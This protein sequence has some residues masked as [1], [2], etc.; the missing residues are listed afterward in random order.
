MK[1]IQTSLFRIAGVWQLGFPGINGKDRAEL[2]GLRGFRYNP[3]AGLWHITFHA[4]TVNFLNNKFDGRYYFLKDPTPRDSVKDFM[5]EEKVKRARLS[6]YRES[7][8]LAVQHTYDRHLYAELKKIE[9]ARYD[10]SKRCWLFSIEQHFELVKLQLERHQFEIIEEEKKL[11]NSVGRISDRRSSVHRS[12]VIGAYLFRFER[13]LALRNQSQRTIASYLGC[14]KVFLAQFKDCD[15][16]EI[17]HEEIRNYLHYLS[18]KHSYSFSTLNL[19]ISAIKSFYLSIFQLRLRQVELPRPKSAKDLPKVIAEDQVKR[20]IE[21]TSN[22]KHRTIL[23][24]MYST[25]I[26]RDEVLGIKL[27]DLSIQEKHILIHGKGKKER[28]VYLPESLCRQVISYLKAYRPQIF[29]FEGKS[30]GSYSA[31]SVAKIIERAGVKAGVK[32][33]VTPHM[34]RHSYATHMLS[35]GVS[36]LHIQKLLGHSSI[37]TTMIY[38]HISDNDLRRLP[39]P[40]DM[41]DL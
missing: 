31:S 3:E 14:I 12:D 34:L 35:K 7:D 10:K 11:L 41:M 6:V 38:T 1:K 40:L 32:Q 36:V 24:T 8:L 37:K 17:S 25:G 16:Q 15:L 4:N 18:N 21:C 27:S 5:P 13:D 20:M 39:N 23:L 30:G 19:H 26:R 9:G 28:M 22:L 33:K 2:S 29:L